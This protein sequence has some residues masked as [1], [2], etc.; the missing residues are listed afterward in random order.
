MTV[1][2]IDLLESIFPRAF[3]VKRIAG[4]NWSF[5]RKFHDSFTD[6]TKQ[7]GGNR[8]PEPHP[9]LLIFLKAMQ[10]ADGLSRAKMP[11]ACMSLQ[12]GNAW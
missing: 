5:F 9:N 2:C 6:G 4:P 8:Q 12:D 11:L 10:N 3:Q 1:V 7:T